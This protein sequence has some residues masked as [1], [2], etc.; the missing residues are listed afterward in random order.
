MPEAEADHPFDAS[1]R[2]LRVLLVF[3]WFLRYVAP[4]AL[5]LRELGVEVG[6]LCRDHAY[7]FDGNVA[8]RERLLDSLTAAG[9]TVLTMPGRVSS[10]AALR[11]AVRV[12]RAVRRWEPDVVH[13]Q[14]EVHDPRMLAVIAAYPVALTVH[15]PRLHLGAARRPL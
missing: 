9:A 13:A 7:E 2:P 1:V 8:E 14:S 5:A 12:A 11:G 6:V 10:T 15:D 3:D 4:Y